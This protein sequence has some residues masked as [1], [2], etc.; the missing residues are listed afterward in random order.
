MADP[1][2]FCFLE[3]FET[4]NLVGSGSLSLFIYLFILMVLVIGFEARFNLMV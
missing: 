3:I 1:L 4:L 2:L